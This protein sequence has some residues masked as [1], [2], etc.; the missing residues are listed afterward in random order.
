MNN[1]K[2]NKEFQE[3]RIE[4]SKFICN[5]DNYIPIVLIKWA[6]RG[7]LN[8][9]VSGKSGAGAGL[10]LSAITDGIKTVMIRKH[11]AAASMTI[12]LASKNL[13]TS[14]E[15]NPSELEVLQKTDIIIHM[16]R[17][18]DVNHSVSIG[19]P[20]ILRYADIAEVSHES[21]TDGKNL[22][23]NP[24]YHLCHCYY[25]KEYDLKTNSYNDKYVL[26]NIFSEKMLDKIRKNCSER[27]K[28]E[29]DLD[30][31]KLLQIQKSKEVVG[32]E[33]WKE[34]ILRYFPW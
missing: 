32:A 2:E 31:E 23:I 13:T 17:Y 34:N 12:N 7:M 11:D 8:I 20:A 21:S 5:R 19:V 18:I 30:M 15:L 26:D 4:L 29:L 27:D 16:D 28:E 24:E 6:T 3:T 22:I 14:T 9:T 33:A 1:K 25:D 10:V